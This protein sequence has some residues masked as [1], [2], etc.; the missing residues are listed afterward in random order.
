MTYITEHSK[1]VSFVNDPVSPHMSAK[2]TSELISRKSNS[3]KHS[4]AF[5]SNKG[6]HLYDYISCLQPKT[7]ERPRKNIGQTYSIIVLKGSLDILFIDDAGNINSLERLNSYL[8]NPEKPFYIRIPANTWY[9]LRTTSNEP[10]I[11]KETHSDFGM[12]KNKKEAIFE[13]SH[14]T[15]WFENQVDI[16]ENLNFKTKKPERFER[17]SENLFTSTRQHVTSQ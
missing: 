2:L 9:S 11:I 1:D 12:I 4:F 3:G 14:D 13:E 5:H 6:V 10:C 8:S 17:V 15:D 16:L 7:I